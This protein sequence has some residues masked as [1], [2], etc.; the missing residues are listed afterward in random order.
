MTIYVSFSPIGVFASDENGRE[1]AFAPFPKDPKLA[2]GAMQDCMKTK[3]SREETE[4]VSKVKENHETTMQPRPKGRDLIGSV[5]S[6]PT[7]N[8][9]LK[10]GVSTVVDELI[11]EVKKEGHKHEFPNPAG[12]ALRKNMILI[13]EKQRLF[14]NRTEFHAFLHTV[15]FELSKGS[16]QKEP[17]NDKLIIHAVN[18]LDEIERTTNTLVMRLR[19]WYGQYFPE[20]GYKLSDNKAFS[21]YISTTLYRSDVRGAEPHDSLGSD[22][23]K[24]DLEEIRVFAKKIL[25]DF[26]AREALEKYIEM[27]SKKVCPNTHAILGGM[28]A[29]RL[30]AHAGSLERLAKFPASTIQILGAERAFFRF[31]HGTGSS[32]KHGVIFNTRYL[33]S[34]PRDKK[35]KVARILAGKLAIALKLDFYGGEFRGDS[36]RKSVDSALQ[37]QKSS[38]RPRAQGHGSFNS[39]SNRPASYSHHS[40]H[41]QKPR[42]SEGSKTSGFHESDRT[43]RPT[44]AAIRNDGS[45]TGNRK[46]SIRP[47]A[48]GH[49][50]SAC[51]KRRK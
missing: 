39:A 43:H 26:K 20:A 47:P 34:A 28:M 22:I 14:K 6:S 46:Q 49:G 7:G 9:D 51:K 29:A 21:E 30:L 41:S 11:F 48:K 16:M 1:R 32:P 8:S 4:V 33:Q 40:N 36:L 25:E 37:N 10:D 45:A 38:M 3:L 23:S 31:K 19:E 5:S 12:D 50:R 44:N 35:G 13:V 24:E 15:N 42:T 27:K 18:A 2:A 17:V